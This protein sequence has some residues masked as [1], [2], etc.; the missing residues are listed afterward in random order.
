MFIEY[1]LE[2]PG[3][4][5]VFGL[6]N[7]DHVTQVQLNATEKS[8]RHLYVQLTGSDEYLSL[9][10]YHDD[11]MN[12]IYNAFM[13]ALTGR[14]GAQIEAVGYVKEAGFQAYW[15]KYWETASQ[16]KNT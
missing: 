14:G 15:T 9:F 11:V 2:I 4:D 16:F 6:I 10:G 13:L 7:S 12:E 5:H 8:S 1:Y 3:G